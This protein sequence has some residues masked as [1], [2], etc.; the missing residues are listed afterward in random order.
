MFCNDLLN[1]DS[2]TIEDL[3]IKINPVTN[4]PEVNCFSEHLHKFLQVRQ[5]KSGYLTYDMKVVLYGTDVN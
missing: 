1:L 5:E 3:H 4:L 2:Q